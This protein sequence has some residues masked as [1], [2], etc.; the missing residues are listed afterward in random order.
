M[1]HLFEESER[2]RTSPLEHGFGRKFGLIEFWRR[3]KRKRRIWL[4]L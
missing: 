2:K 4:E 3:M 1:G